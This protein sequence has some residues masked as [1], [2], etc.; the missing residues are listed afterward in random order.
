MVTRYSIFVIWVF[1]MNFNIFY[2]QMLVCFMCGFE[3]S[4][5]QLL[6]CVICITVRNGPAP[7]RRTRFARF[8]H[9][10]TY[11]YI[12]AYIYI[13]RKE[14]CSN[15]SRQGNAMQ[16]MIEVVE[17]WSIGVLRV[18]EYWSIGVLEYWS[19]GVL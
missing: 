9:I 17:Y 7:L 14:R 4:Y 19:I 12:Y 16:G 15:Y 18:S 5:V 11:I 3:W 2:V 10:Y 8:E 6:A 13:Q 1:C